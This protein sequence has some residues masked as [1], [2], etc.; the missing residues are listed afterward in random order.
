MD[1]AGIKAE[2]SGLEKDFEEYH[3]VKILTDKSEEQLKSEI[4]KFENMVNNI[5]SV[6]LNALEIYESVE[7]E[8]NKLI[9]KKDK[10]TQERE[11]VISMMNEIENKKI[12]LFM[13]TYNMVNDHFKDI[14]SKLS[15]KGEASLEL[16][17]PKNPF[18]GGLGIKVRLSGDKFMD[19]RGLS[20]GEKTMTAL[21]FIF[22]IQEH[23]PA[24]FYV[25]DE[26][27][28]ALD[29]KNSE[30]LAKLVRK[31]SENSQYVMISHNDGIITEADNIY[32]V[33]MNE[34]GISQIVSL[35]I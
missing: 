25:L 3:G 33:S 2:L 12:E 32:G 11:D 8:Y 5:G 7:Q 18:E 22:A 26:V 6:N 9:E 30:K 24:T 19:I 10:L 20:G 17:D 35:K 14:F 23:D 21:A 16:E 15:T 1:V 13:K 31:Y 34:H 28:A 4:K 29:K 27:D